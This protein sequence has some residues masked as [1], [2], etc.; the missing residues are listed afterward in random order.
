MKK[1]KKLT[2]LVVSDF[3]G[4]SEK[5]LEVVYKSLQNKYPDYGIIP[6]MKEAE[7]NEIKLRYDT[8]VYWLVTIEPTIVN[9]TVRVAYFTPSTKR[10]SDILEVTFKKG[11]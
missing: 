11:L 10:Y 1:L 4:L 8:F 2:I 7:L 3:A 9:R 5:Q 6:K